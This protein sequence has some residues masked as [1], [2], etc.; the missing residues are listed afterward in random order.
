M[1]IFDGEL[2]PWSALG[3]GLIEKHFKTI[4]KALTSE[5]QILEK[6]GFDKAL[7]NMLTSGDY[8]AF[9]KKS[10]TVSKKDLQK[11]V[12]LANVSTY[13]ALQ[14]YAKLKR[15]LQEKITD[16]KIYHEQVDIFSASAPLSYLPFDILK[17]IKRD[18]TEE[19]RFG[20]ATNYRL[21]HET[22]RDLIIDLNATDASTLAHAYFDKITNEER[23]EGVVVKPLWGE[24]KN[25]FCVPYMKVRNSKYLT[26]VYGYDYT[27]N[28]KYNKLLNNKGIKQKLKASL[29]DALM[30]QQM[31]QYKLTDINTN[32]EEYKMLVASFLFENEKQ[33][34]IDPR[35]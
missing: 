24:K 10:E 31:L 18:G 17:V 3:E 35:L 5:L 8:T 29:K 25:R 1:I 6:S 34:S 4:D 20:D 26:L 12:G 21:L 23:M 7:E 9:S 15:P 2:L 32:N 19:I 33:S 11:Q 30:G 22:E 27:S 28:Y 16:S 13:T 14:E